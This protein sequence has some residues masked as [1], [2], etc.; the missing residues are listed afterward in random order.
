MSDPSIGETWER[1]GRRWEVQRIDL[2]HYVVYLADPQH[3]EHEVMADLGN[4]RSGSTGW[5]R[6]PEVSP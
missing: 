5:K 6:V 4:M 2:T 1:N 3:P